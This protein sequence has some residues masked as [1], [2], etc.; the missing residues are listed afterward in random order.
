MAEVGEDGDDLV[1]M[2][3]G[4]QEGTDVRGGAEGVED[5]ELVLDAVRGGGHVDL[6]QGHVL[7]FAVWIV[8]GQCCLLTGG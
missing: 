3:E 8:F 2:A 6:L 4:G 7:G 5:F 1:E